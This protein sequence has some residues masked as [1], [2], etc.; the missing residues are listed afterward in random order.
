LI[1]SLV[2]VVV[3]DVIAAAQLALFH[4]ASSLLNFESTRF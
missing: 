4:R 3:A 1:L 2:V